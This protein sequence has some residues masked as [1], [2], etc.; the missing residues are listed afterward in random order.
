M[1]GFGSAVLHQWHHNNRGK[2]GGVTPPRP[3]PTSRL[4]VPQIFP[5]LEADAANAPRACWAAQRQRRLF[6][7]STAVGEALL[8]APTDSP[9]QASQTRRRE[10]LKI[11]IT[12]IKE[13]TRGDKKQ[14]KSK[15]MRACFFFCILYYRRGVFGKFT[16]NDKR[17]KTMISPPWPRSLVYHSNNSI[18]P[19]CFSTQ[20]HSCHCEI[21]A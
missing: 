14:N 15:G 16:T 2:W 18:L 9:Q 20:S 1:S 11:H 4:H 10:L 7:G 12:S 13:A 3:L 5:Q 19:V 21:K 8:N 6:C 17:P